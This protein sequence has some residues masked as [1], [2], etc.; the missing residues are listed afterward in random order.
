[1]S[2]IALEICKKSTQE[3]IECNE[4]AVDP[5][6][7][8]YGQDPGGKDDENMRTPSPIRLPFMS[9]LHVV[10]GIRYNRMQMGFTW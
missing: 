6:N 1:M 4:V 10:T 5:I 3:I 9:Q 8:T 7:S 2:S